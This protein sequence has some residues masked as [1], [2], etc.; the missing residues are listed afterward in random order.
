M[1]DLTSMVNDLYR[2]VNEMEE[3]VNQWKAERYNILNAVPQVS[4]NRTNALTALVRAEEALAELNTAT[5][6]VA[7]ARGQRLK[8]LLDGLKNSMIEIAENITSSA[9]KRIGIEV[10]NAISEVDSVIPD[11]LKL[12]YRLRNI[13]EMAEQGLHYMNEE[14]IIPYKHHITSSLESRVYDMPAIDGIV[15]IDGEVTVLDENLEPILIDDEI[16]TAI[17]TDKGRI[18]LSN[19]LTIPVYVYFPVKMKKKDLPE[20]V[21][22]YM[23]D[24]MIQKNSRLMKTVL[25]FEQEVNQLYE[26]I[27]A[28][29]GES[30]TV[31]YS[32]MRN[33]RDI[34]RESI[35]P[36]GLNISVKN[37][38]V[39]ATFS[40][41]DHP[42]LSHFILEKRNEQTGEWEPY[43]G[44]A[45]IIYK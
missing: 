24:M 21:L 39:H 15:Y 41:S 26:D 20:D 31:D 18:I 13:Q 12:D 36:K 42:N 32:I 4:V 6:G 38:M 1:A 19:S 17:I 27:R 5:F 45:G 28:M 8:K 33:H 3:Y 2:R 35:T 7:A 22:L 14:L 37:G 34:I 43:D 25:K 10:D 9:D 29:K 30:W 11:G 16:V 40:Y 44:V 23:I